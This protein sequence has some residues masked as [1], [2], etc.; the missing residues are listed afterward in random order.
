[1]FFGWVVRWK[2]MAFSSIR[3]NGVT[4]LLLIIN[5][6]SGPQRNQSWYLAKRMSLNSIPMHRDERLPSYDGVATVQSLK[7][8][9]TVFS[10]RHPEVFTHIVTHPSTRGNLVAKKIEARGR[11]GRAMGC[12]SLQIEGGV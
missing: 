7:V 4:Y 11:D 1:M 8:N 9:C 12:G 5:A 3:L 10:D 6:G 2:S